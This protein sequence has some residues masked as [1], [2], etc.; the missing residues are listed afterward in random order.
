VPAFIA[1][2]APS[3]LLAPPRYGRL[4]AGLPLP[5]KTPVSA[6]AALS[7]QDKARI[8]EENLYE[9]AGRQFSMASR[10]RGTAFASRPQY[11]SDVADRN[12]KR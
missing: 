9:D 6:A 8:I 10:L 12:V 3:E 2:I 1:A 5:S 11:T 7:Q 4:A